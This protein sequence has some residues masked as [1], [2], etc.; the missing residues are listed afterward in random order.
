M[1]KTCGKTIKV[2]RAYANLNY[3]Y[4]NYSYR[5][6]ENCQRSCVAYEM[7]RRGYDVMAKAAPHNDKL[8]V[9]ELYMN[10]FKNPNIV[11][12]NK[13]QRKFQTR[14]NKLENGRYFVQVAWHND[15]VGHVFIVEKHGSRVYS[16]DPQ[17]N[18]TNVL[19]DYSNRG[20]IFSYTKVDELELDN[21]FIKKCVKPIDY[22]DESDII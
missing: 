20:R 15:T 8:C 12:I 9:D 18:E 11:Y 19:K 22:Y 21:N 5:Y 7:L 13:G 2:A 6:T 3:Q 16:I 1:N 4:D 17:T 10:A 14:L